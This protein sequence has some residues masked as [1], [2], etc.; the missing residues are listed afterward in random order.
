MEELQQVLSQLEE[1]VMVEREG[2]W[3][4]GSSDPDLEG[5]ILEL[6]N[7]TINNSFELDRSVAELYGV[8]AD[9]I[10]GEGTLRRLWLKLKELSR[11][12]GLKRKLSDSTEYSNNEAS[13][14]I[15]GSSDNS[16]FK[17]NGRTN[18]FSLINSLSTVYEILRDA[19]TFGPITFTCPSLIPFPQTFK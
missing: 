1:G 4:E 3:G 18:I 2:D 11:V 13:T 12:C 14:S 10:G 15:Q 19:F 16:M 8:R 7:S 17:R 5:E 9:S 6:I